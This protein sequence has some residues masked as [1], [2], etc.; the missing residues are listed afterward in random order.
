MKIFS[1][2]LKILVLAAIISYLFWFSSG[3]FADKTASNHKTEVGKKSGL[4]SKMENITITEKNK[5]GELLQVRAVEA[6]ISDRHVE[7]SKLEVV[8]HP[9]GQPPINLTSETGFLQNKTNDAVFSGNV[10]VKSERPFQLESERFDWA[11]ELKLLTTSEKVTLVRDDLTVLGKGMIMNLKTEDVVVLESVRATSSLSTITGNR[12]EF[13]NSPK[14]AVVTGNAKVLQKGGK[15][16]DKPAEDVEINSDEIQAFADEG[17]KEM[18]RV[19]AKGN[20][21]I[22]TEDRTVTGDYGEFFKSPKK[23]FVSGNAMIV[24]KVENK[25]SKG[26]DEVHINSDEIEALSGEGGEELEKVT[27]R[28]NVIIVTEKRRITGDVTELFSKE[29]KV[30]VSGNATLK[31]DEDDIKG[32]KIIYFYDK[33]DIIISGGSGKRAKML[34]T[35]QKQ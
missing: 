8:F 28:G 18:D 21:V 22:V 4:K 14:K 5:D 23:M 10:V 31:E 30:V 20:V 9:S 6:Q 17:S 26:V 7:L 35:P 33:D 19:T 32:E 16:G 24:Q 2:V 1:K 29:K 27:A 13:F 11:S 15:R 3:M 25:G 12:G 34:L